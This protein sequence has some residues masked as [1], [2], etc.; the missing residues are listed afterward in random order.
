MTIART[1]ALS[2]VTRGMIAACLILCGGFFALEAQAA[3][4]EAV[5]VTLS[6][7]GSLSMEPGEVVEVHATYQNAGE[8]TWSNDGTGYISLYTSDPS[9]RRSVFD[10]GTWL[11]PEQVTRINETSVAPG[12][13]ASLSFELRA[14]ETE[15]TYREAFFL[16][17]ENTAW[18]ANGALILTIEV[19][20]EEEETATTTTA[21]SDSYDAAITV[22]TANE[23]KVRAGASVLFTVGVKNTGTKTWGSYALQEADVAIASTSSDFSHP[24]W[25]GTQ[26]AYG[27]DS[28]SPGETAVLTFAF[29]A[30]SS[31]GTH[32]AEFE[33]RADGNVIDDAFLE[34]P[35]EVTGGSAAVVEEEE[36]EEIDVDEDG[37]ITVRDFQEEPVVRVGLLTVDEETDDII[38][39]TSYES[40]FE[41]RD[42]EGNIL[43]ALSAGE[44]VTGYYNGGYYYYDVGRGLEQSTYGLRFIPE[45][46]NA[47]MTITNFDYRVTRNGG[48]AYNTYRNVLE[49]RYN[50]YKDRT[51]VI[52][53]LP[54]E[55]YLRGLAET[56]NV[57]HFEYQKALVTAARTY[58]FY[59]YTRGTKR[60][61]EHMHLVAYADDQVYRGY[62]RETMS[63]NVVQA[64][65]DT[66]GVIVTYD[67]DYAI[68]PYFS[69]SD[70]RTRDWSEVWGGEVAWAKSVPVPW[71]EG[72][73]LWGHGVGMS[74]VGALAM[75]NEGWLY[76]EILPYYYTDIEL[77]QWWEVAD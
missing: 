27:T 57:S 38:T 23:I 9:Y 64:V 39:I 40:D 51:W 42:T 1:L 3:T 14:P 8:A 73:T 11:G 68:T 6:G 53:E 62:E 46:E 22:R 54:I 49:I 13:T 16:A 61:S 59:H 33:F 75:A 52:N 17:S 15:G 72:Y 71:D 7:S 48:Y 77:Q 63:P 74:A 5:P 67:D 56:S 45:V 25:S 30:P 44:L 50:D 28:I 58:A 34:I 32:M 65:E 69:R 2:T 19:G 70:G 4:Y 37:A 26:L 41:L 47:V 60:A 20:E 35:V 10:P 76:E 66:H 29:T 43:A 12:E 21:S 24:S 18:M 36:D 31:N 55:M